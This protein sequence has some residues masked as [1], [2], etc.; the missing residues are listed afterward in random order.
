MTTEATTAASRALRT[1][2]LGLV[3]GVLAA[4]V[5]AWRLGLLDILAEPAR[6]RTWIVDQG[7]YGQLA[8]VLAFTLLQPFG[9][10]GTVFLLVAPLLWPW[11]EAYALC[12]VGTMAA[13]VVGF[14][15]ARFVARD[16]VER[17]VPARLRGYEEALARRAFVTVV[18]LRFV[19]WMPPA[20]HAFFG[21]S[22][23]S[24]A[25]HFWGSLVGYALPLLGMAY[26]GE[27]LF[28]WLA[29]VPAAVWLGL[30]ALLVAGAVVAIV[31][32]MRRR[33]SSQTRHPRS[34]APSESAP[35]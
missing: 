22:R 6:L 3:M 20:L 32:M 8:F 17:R 11:H 13:S 25:T 23:V 27:D 18:M 7:A 26:F 10:P 16:F 9:L 12:M 5:A 24:F 29:E 31:V 4:L 30:G 14:S 19:L 34:G 1:A 28:T 15:F 21:V 33:A 2:K 35:P